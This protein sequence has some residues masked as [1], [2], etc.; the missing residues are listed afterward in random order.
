MI[1]SCP[2]AGTGIAKY[3][4]MRGIKCRNN[5]KSV[6]GNQQSANIAD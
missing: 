5:I 2:K 6:V 3:F 4:T 1:R